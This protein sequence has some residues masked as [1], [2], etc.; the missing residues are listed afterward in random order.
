MPAKCKRASMDRQACL[1]Y[2]SHFGVLSV[3]R[4]E[5][6]TMTTVT[7]N[8]SKGGFLP[9]STP[10]LIRGGNYNKWVIDDTKEY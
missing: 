2:V 6:L 9:E 5:G 10:Y 1:E 4:I 8:L 7:L 3:T